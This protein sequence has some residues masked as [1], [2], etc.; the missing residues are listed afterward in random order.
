MW[1]ESEYLPLLIRNKAA[2]LLFGNI[3]AERVYSCYRGQKTGQNCDQ[4][5]HCTETIPKATGKAVVDS[6]PSGADESQQVAGKHNHHKNVDLH[7]I[8]LI[9]L[10]ILLQQGKNSPLKFEVTVDTSLEVENGRFEMV[11]VSIPCMRTR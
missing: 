11:S 9:V 1:D 7:L 10:K 5:N 2:E 8:W 4:K 6:C 3:K